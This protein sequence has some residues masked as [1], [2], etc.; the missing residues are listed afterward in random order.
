ML[1]KRKTALI[2]TRS[3]ANCRLAP[4]NTLATAPRPRAC[5]S[6]YLAG[7]RADCHRPA[8][9]SAGSSAPLAA[10]SWAIPTRPLWPLKPSSKPAA[11]A[12]A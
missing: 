11:A 9:I 2:V 4:G 8:T 3:A 7:I 5:F 1:G 12:I 6:V 10:R